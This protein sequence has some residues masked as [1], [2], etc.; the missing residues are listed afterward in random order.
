M[1]AFSL[2]PKTPGNLIWGG[3]ARGEEKPPITRPNSSR[4][5]SSLMPFSSGYTAEIQTFAKVSAAQMSWPR[6]FFTQFIMSGCLK[7][8]QSLYHGRSVLASIA[9]T[10]ISRKT[11]GIWHP[12]SSMIRRQPTSL[13]IMGFPTFEAKT[14]CRRQ[15]HGSCPRPLCSAQKLLPQTRWTQQARRI[16]TA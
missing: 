1:S 6:F 16:L 4:P 5:P 7:V 8:L 12:A 14:R 10:A 11:V 2:F 9:N 13:K 3:S 15:F